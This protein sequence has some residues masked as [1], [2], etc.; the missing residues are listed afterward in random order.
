[1]VKLFHILLCLISCASASMSLSG[2]CSGTGSHLMEL[3]IEGLT[4]DQAAFLTAS[5]IGLENISNVSYDGQVTF[6]NGSVMWLNE[7]WEMVA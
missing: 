2:N 5:H 6:R 4:L 1:M 7:T 3:S